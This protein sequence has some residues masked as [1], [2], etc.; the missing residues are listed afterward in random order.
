MENIKKL[1]F[2]TSLKFFSAVFFLIL[3][4]FNFLDIYIF[5]LS[6]SF[7]GIFFNFFTNYIDPLSDILDPFI[8]II[9]CGLILL[10]NSD[11]SLILKNEN[12]LAVIKEKTGFSFDKISYLFNYLSLVCKHFIFSLTVA[13]ILCNIFKYILGVSRPKYFFL[14]GYERMNFFNI[15]Q[16]INSFPSGH[17]QAAFTLAILLIIYLNKYTFYILFFACL[18]GLSRI[19]MSMHFPSDL[20]AG[21][22]LGSI[23]PVFLYNCFYRKEIEKIKNKYDVF[24]TDIVKLLYWRFYI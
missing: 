18:M 19:F 1:E 10:L 13:G 3:F 9:F 6:R 15:E 20:I 8:L 21:A 12:K 17:T 4:F 16:K 14:E 24:L 23:I 7:P 2:L 22:Y 11:I 5:E